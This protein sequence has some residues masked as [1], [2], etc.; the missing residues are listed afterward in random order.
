MMLLAQK[1]VMQKLRD[2]IRLGGA[3]QRVSVHVT[4]SN[5]VIKLSW[6]PCNSHATPADTCNLYTTPSHCGVGLRV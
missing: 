5:E 6:Q 1:L 2:N 4:E 3:K